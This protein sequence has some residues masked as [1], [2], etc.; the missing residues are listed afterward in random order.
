[1][2]DN[3]E[4]IWMPQY[5]ENDHDVVLYL[6]AKRKLII[7]NLSQDYSLESRGVVVVGAILHN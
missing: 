1:M 3:S 7:I 2:F 4:S 6:L 5:H